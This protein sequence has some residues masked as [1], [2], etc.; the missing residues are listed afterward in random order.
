MI[1]ELSEASIRLLNSKKLLSPVE[2]YLI[3]PVKTTYLL[4]RINISKI[5]IELVSNLPTSMKISYMPVIYGI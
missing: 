3:L 2:T 1:P 4:K 5:P